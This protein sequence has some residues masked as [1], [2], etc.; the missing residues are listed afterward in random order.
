MAYLDSAGNV[1]PVAGRTVQQWT[2]FHATQAAITDNVARGH[3]TA[4]VTALPA[5]AE[6]ASKRS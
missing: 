6:K 2:A 4:P 5:G 1:D 3:V